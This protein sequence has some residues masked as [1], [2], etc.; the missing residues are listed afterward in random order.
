[1]GNKQTSA[2]PVVDSD[3]CPS[4]HDADCKDAS[5]I[6]AALDTLGLVD[7]ISQHNHLQASID[8]YAERK[9]DDSPPVANVEDVLRPYEDQSFDDD[10]TAYR[11]RPL[12]LRDGQAILSTLKWFKDYKDI[13]LRFHTTV[14]HPYLEYRRDDGTKALLQDDI[15]MLLLRHNT[16]VHIVYAR[17]LDV[18][19]TDEDA[20]RKHVTNKAFVLRLALQAHMLNRVV[21]EFDH[22]DF[23]ESFRA[24]YAQEP[25]FMAIVGNLKE[26]I[27]LQVEFE[28]T[29]EHYLS[30]ISE[31]IT[32]C[33]PEAP[34]PT[35]PDGL[36]SLEQAEKLF[37]Q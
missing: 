7:F 16:H 19:D 25:R 9:P 4:R 22:G 15:D 13:E 6:R 29:L 3:P 36:P 17:V 28:R 27:V 14:K 30:E 1:M 33:A 8:A 12:E 20:I 34:R 2:K 10:R 31:H 35:E 23:T 24:A 21:Q 37:D 5:V 32:T 26:G 11:A 18:T